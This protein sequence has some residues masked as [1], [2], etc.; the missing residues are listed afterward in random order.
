MSSLLK[1]VAYNAKLYYKDPEYM[2]NSI[3]EIL[4]Q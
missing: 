2:Q 3:N 1:R 4:E